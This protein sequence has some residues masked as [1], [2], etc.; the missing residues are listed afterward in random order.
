MEV[1]SLVVY[2]VKSCAGVSVRSAVLQGWGDGC[3]GLLYDRKWIILREDG[4][5]RMRMATQRNVPSLCLIACQ[6][7]PEILAGAREATEADS[8]ELSMRGGSEALNIPLL[9]RQSTTA[10]A[11]KL[12]VRVWGWEGDVVDEGDEAA[13]WVTE[14][15]RSVGGLGDGELLRL[16]RFDSSAKR[17][18]EDD[19][20]RIGGGDARVAQTELSD[21]F[22]ILLCSSSSLDAVNASCGDD[23]DMRR[24]RPN[25][26]VR[27]ALAFEEDTWSKLKICATSGEVELSLVKPCARCTVPEVNQDTGSPAPAT[28]VDEKDESAH[29]KTVTAA[30]RAL[31]RRGDALGYSNKKLV[32]GLFFGWNCLHT[33]TVDC[34]MQGSIVTVGDSARPVPRDANAAAVF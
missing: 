21:G 30:L 14:A 7:D 17:I 12:R 9:P 25:I 28:A 6:I 20:K 27:G 16:A 22:P 26:C 2:P 3:G 5:G 31:G 29:P 10:A 24:F 4:E 32:N 1:S 15:M 18:V 34:P 11:R 8:L 33:S 19:Y 13:A 23:V